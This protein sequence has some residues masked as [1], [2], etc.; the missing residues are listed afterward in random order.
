MEKIF[1]VELTDQGR[2]DEVDSW[3]TKR[4]ALARIREIEADVAEHP[5]WYRHLAA[6][7]WSVREWARHEA[8]VCVGSDVLTRHEAQH[9]IL[10]TLPPSLV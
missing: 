2:T 3:N 10:E 7:C 4:E 1:I 6:P 8:G 5:Q 9:L